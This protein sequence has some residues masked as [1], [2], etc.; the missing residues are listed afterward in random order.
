MEEGRYALNK[1]SV[2]IVLRRI[3]TRVFAK[4]RKIDGETYTRY[5]EMLS[6]ILTGR[7][8]QSKELEV[9]R[10]EILAYGSS[11]SVRDLEGFDIGAN[12]ASMRLLE[13]CERLQGEE[14]ER[15]SRS[16][17]VRRHVKMLQI[18]DQNPGITQK[19]LAEK[20]SVSPSNLSQTLARLKPYGLLVVSRMG[21]NKHYNLTLQAQEVLRDMNAGQARANSTVDSYYVFFEAKV[22]AGTVDALGRRNQMYEWRHAVS[23]H[24]PATHKDCSLSLGSSPE[25]NAFSS[26]E[27]YTNEATVVDSRQ[28][29]FSVC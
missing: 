9:L 14:D 4:K 10:H 19:Q 22:H 28:K 26:G 7:E 3:S 21:R 23:Q 24:I 8:E 20:L 11:A 15:R 16:A 27:F 18:V 25:A 17:M 5:F 13:E 2:S 12:W 1:Q 29:L 6:N